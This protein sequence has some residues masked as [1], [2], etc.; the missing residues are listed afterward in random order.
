MY[1]TQFHLS[2]SHCLALLFVY[3]FC[4]KLSSCL[5]SIKCSCQTHFPDKENVEG[6]SLAPAAVSI[7]CDSAAVHNDLILAREHSVRFP[8]NFNELNSIANAIVIAISIAVAVYAFCTFLINFLS[9]FAQKQNQQKKRQKLCHNCDFLSHTHVL[10]RLLT[11]ICAM[12][13]T[14]EVYGP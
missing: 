13:E 10:L 2:R 11:T 3:L 9:T 6:F 4:H 12:L 8:A 5:N 14:A 7:F 1:R